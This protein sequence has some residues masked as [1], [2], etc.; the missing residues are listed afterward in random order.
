MLNCVNMWEKNNGTGACHCWK[1]YTLFHFDL[2]LIEKPTMCVGRR[3]DSSHFQ[4]ALG[5]LLSNPWVGT[6]LCGG[7]FRLR[8]PDRGLYLSYFTWETYLNFL[9]KSF[10]Q[11]AI[12]VHWK[13]F[14]CLCYIGM[15][16]CQGPLAGQLGWR[17]KTGNLNPQEHV[18]QTVEICGL[19]SLSKIKKCWN[20]DEK[21]FS[22][23]IKEQKW[24]SNHTLISGLI[25]R[26]APH[27]LRCHRYL[28]GPA[29]TTTVPTLP[30]VPVREL[31][32]VAI[33]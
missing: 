10:A 7:W 14:I 24:F 13:G 20:P 18:F 21:I 27:V 25:I 6:R 30:E 28:L 12:W 9:K 26:W 2:I 4:V 16:W 17:M 5:I 32:P 15:R 19:W 23:Q 29:Q 3:G 31:Q 11:E 1:L 22:S 8:E 33:A